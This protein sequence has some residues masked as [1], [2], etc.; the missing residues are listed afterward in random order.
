MGSQY[1]DRAII[2]ERANFTDIFPGTNVS[3]KEGY[4][5]KMINMDTNQPQMLPKFM[6]VEAESDSEIVLGGVSLSINGMTLPQTNCVDYGFRLIL[7]GGQ[8]KQ[9]I[10]YMFDRGTTIVY[11]IN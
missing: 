9:C 8:V 11:D 7:Q 5:V 1:C 10:L 3:P 6:E 4:I 2:I